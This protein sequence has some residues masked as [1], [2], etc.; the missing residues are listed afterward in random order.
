V[1]LHARDEAERETGE[2]GPSAACQGCCRWLEQENEWICKQPIVCSGGTYGSRHAHMRKKSAGPPHSKIFEAAPSTP[3]GSPHVWLLS[4][5]PSRTWPPSGCRL[6]RLRLRQM[7]PL[8]LRP[9]HAR[10]SSD[11]SETFFVCFEPGLQYRPSLER[12][13]G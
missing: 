11:L 1:R 8:T 12:L 9:Y 10:A 13:N 4:S 5:E 6:I 7:R 3:Q 2:R